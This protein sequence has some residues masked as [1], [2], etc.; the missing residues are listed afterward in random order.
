MSR[1]V[2][3]QEEEMSTPGCGVDALSLVGFNTGAWEAPLSYHWSK[4]FVLGK[5]TRGEFIGHSVAGHLL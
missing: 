3:A 1:Q 5:A 2:W 4:S